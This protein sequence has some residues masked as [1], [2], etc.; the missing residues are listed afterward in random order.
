[1]NEMTVKNDVLPALLEK[2]SLGEL[3]RPLVKEIHLF[4]TVIAGTIYIEDEEW[5]AQLQTGEKLSLQ[6]EDNRYDEKA[7]VIKNGKGDKLGYVPQ[8]D[9]AVFSRLMDA[10]KRLSAKVNYAR[11]TDGF[12][13]V[14]IGIYLEDF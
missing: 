12:Y 3:I 7:I 11:K 9:N 1:M 4:D 8:R 5:Y 14:G 13:R 10:G 2:N 6:R